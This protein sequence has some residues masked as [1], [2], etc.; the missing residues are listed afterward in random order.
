[1]AAHAFS[2]LT[3]TAE[4]ALEPGDRLELLAAP[5]VRAS[6]RLRLPPDLPANALPVTVV[7]DE[8][9]Q[10][11]PVLFDPAAATLLAP[12]WGRSLPEDWGAVWLEYQSPGRYRLLAEEAPASARELT[13]EQGVPIRLS[14]ADRDLVRFSPAPPRLPDWQL[15]LRAARL[16]THGSFDQLICLPL[17]RDMEILASSTHGK[18]GDGKAAVVAVAALRRRGGVGATSWLRGAWR[19]QWCDP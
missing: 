7:E 16:A 14:D 12:E 8:R 9:G 19:W 6:G 17:V 15:A 18:Q 5:D 1:M 10:P 11:L 4:P 2:L 13:T 3:P